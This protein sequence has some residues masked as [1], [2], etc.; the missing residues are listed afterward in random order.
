MSGNF[1]FVTVKGDLFIT[2]ADEHGI[3]TERKVSNLVVQL[4]K[5]YIVHRMI[6]GDT[7]TVSRM[8]IGSGSAVAVST[9]TAL[10]NQLARVALL[11]VS[12][13]SNVV[14]YVA[15]FPAG[16]GNGAITEAGL[17]TA[18]S[19]GIMLARSVFP[20][21]NKMANDKITITWNITIQ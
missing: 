11:S 17:F 14:T 20:V 21:V 8:G 19:G 16:T 7:A 5:E 1:D 4:G 18:A 12:Q 13:T 3:H 2:V 9:D 10:G 15:E 6:A